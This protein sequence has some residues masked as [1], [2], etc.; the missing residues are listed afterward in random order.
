M[1]CGHAVPGLSL[2]C[3]VYLMDGDPRRYLLASFRGWY[4]GERRTRNRRAGPARPL[5]GRE[6]E[7]ARL[8]AQGLDNGQIGA[9]LRVSRATVATHVTGILSKLGFTSRVQVAAWVGAGPNGGRHP[10]DHPD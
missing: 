5:T 4:R 8:V 6:R 1:T 2:E 3:D 10:S 7:V 9:R